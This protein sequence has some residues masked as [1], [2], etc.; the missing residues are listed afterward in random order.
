MQAGP[1]HGGFRRFRAAAPRRPKRPR[2]TEVASGL[3]AP[4]NLVLSGKRYVA[5]G[6]GT[7]GRAIPG[8]TANRARSRLLERITLP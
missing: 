8:P 3:D 1:S 5:E 6:M 7:P 2:V 4:T